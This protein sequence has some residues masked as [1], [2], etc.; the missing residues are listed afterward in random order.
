MKY[1]VTNL[2]REQS[3]GL[4]LV[5]GIKIF[6]PLEVALVELSDNQVNYYSQIGEASLWRIEA[7]VFEPGQESARE[8]SVEPE[9]EPEP[10]PVQAQPLRRKRRR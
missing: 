3:R 9:Q 4:V 10:E 6:S 7:E 5:D 1:K 2:H 8:E